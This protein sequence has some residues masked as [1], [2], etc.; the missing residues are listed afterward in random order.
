MIGIFWGIGI[1]YIKKHSIG[2]GKYR[3][4]WGIGIGIG[5]NNTD[6][7][8]LIASIGFC[9]QLILIPNIRLS[10]QVIASQI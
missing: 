7:P 9:A 1:G 2:I 3:N 10:S 5:K 6:P 4:F 8:S